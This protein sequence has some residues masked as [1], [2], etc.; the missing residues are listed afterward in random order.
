MTHSFVLASGNP[1]DEPMRSDVGMTLGS[2]AVDVFFVTSGFLV[3]ASLIAR[4]GTLEFVA[5][6]F[7]RIYPALW[8]MVGITV[9]GLGAAVTTL[10]LAEYLSAAATRAYLWKCATLIGGVAY[11]LPGVFPDT[12]YPQAVN[13]SLWTM[14]YEIKMYLILAATWLALKPLASRRI[15]TFQ[16]MIVAAATLAGGL[17]LANFYVRDVNSEFTKLFFMFFS[18]A[19]AF[20]LRDRIVLSRGAALTMV[21]ALPLA[22][23][24]GREVFFGVHT[25]SV[26]YLVLALAYLPGGALRAYNRLGDYSY[27][28]YIY[29]FPI[30]QLICHLAPGISAEALMAFSAGATLVCAVLSWHLLEKQ[31]LAL[32]GRFAWKRQ[33][34]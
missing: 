32:K 5:A 8:A 21:A 3:T 7:L 28:V 34:T 19:A 9:L 10:P 11:F 4:R 22:Y 18:G 1:D 13:G 31:A 27:G 12:P 25:L 30:Q 16:A 20:V 24:G 17:V 26:G 6:R 29:A 2:M 33:E 23:L 14:P 15:R